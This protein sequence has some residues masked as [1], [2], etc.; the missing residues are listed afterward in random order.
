[1]NS[2]YLIAGLA[3][4]AV[5]GSATAGLAREGERRMG[6]GGPGGFG[7]AMLME[8]FDEVD[9]DGDGAVTEAELEAHAKARF[10]AADSNGDGKLDAAELEARAEQARQERLARMA[11][12][13]IDRA[14]SDGDGAITFAEAEAARPDRATRL[15]ERADADDDGAISR[16]EAEEAL[17]RFGERRGHKRGD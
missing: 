4:L 11:A 7:G 8:R 9:A 6:P 16:E 17:K 5:L 2:R 3:A 15:F 10:D 1:M 12:R 13:M 14:D